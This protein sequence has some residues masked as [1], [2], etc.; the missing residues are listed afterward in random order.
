[1]LILVEDW[2]VR[3][4]QGSFLK[5]AVLPGTAKCIRDGDVH[6]ELAWLVCGV[7]VQ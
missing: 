6:W 7:R 1:M 5:S 2:E 3:V 4:E